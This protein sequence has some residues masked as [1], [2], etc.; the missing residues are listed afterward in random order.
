MHGKGN[1]VFFRQG[2]RFLNLF[3]TTGVGRVGGKHGSD[4]FVPLPLLD[5]LFG[6]GESAVR[7][8]AVA[9]FCA[10]NGFA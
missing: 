2:R 3:G 1:T 7:F 4:K 10:H 9:G 6:Q 5:K 8:R